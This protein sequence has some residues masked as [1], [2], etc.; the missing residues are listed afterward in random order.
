MDFREADRR[1]AELKRQY[2]AGSLSAQ[3]L[4]EQRRQLLVLD[5]E[6]RWWA[7]SRESGQ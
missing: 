1:Y 6:G 2:Q 4:D 7:K 5:D 3:Q